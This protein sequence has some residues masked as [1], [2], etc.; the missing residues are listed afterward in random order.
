MSPAGVEGRPD[1]GLVRHGF[2]CRHGLPQQRCTSVLPSVSCLLRSL[3]GERAISLQLP[4]LDITL[5]LCLGP[6]WGVSSLN[7]LPR[8]GPVPVPR[9]QG[10]WEPFPAPL[11]RVGLP[12]YTSLLSLL[13]L[14][15]CPCCV[16]PSLPVLLRGVCRTLGLCCGGSLFEYSPELFFLFHSAQGLCFRKCHTQKFTLHFPA[17]QSNPCAWGRVPSPALLLPWPALLRGA[18]G[19][20]RLHP[21]S[22]ICYSRVGSTRPESLGALSKCSPGWTVL[23]S[24][25]LVASAPRL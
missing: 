3:Q 15:L 7:S 2:G 24:L 20:S 19:T 9:R 10:S 18:K 14:A 23:T 22:C 8:P 5:A 11:W 12:V 13:P 16:S 4:R 25:P 17:F 6:L 21:P 1:T